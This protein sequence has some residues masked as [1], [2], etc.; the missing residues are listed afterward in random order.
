MNSFFVRWL[1]LLLLVISSMFLTTTAVADPLPGRDLLKFSQLPMISTAIQDPIIPPNPNLV[2]VTAAATPVTFTNY[3]GHDELS[4]IYGFHGS[5]PTD[6]PQTYSGR[7]MADDFADK[8]NSPVVHVK[9]W[10]SYLGDHIVEPLNRFLISFES[11]QQVDANNPFSHP[12]QPLLTQT[13][14]RATTLTPGIGAFTEKLIRSPDPVRHESLYEYNAELHIDKP[15]P[16]KAHNVYW[17]KIAA[18]IDT[19][20][21]SSNFDP[22]NPQSGPFSGDNPTVWGWHNRDYTIQDTLA[23]TAVAPGEVLDGTINGSPIYHFQDDAVGGRLIA[24][25]TGPGAPTVAQSNMTPAF[26]VDGADGPAAIAGA[27]GIS[28]YSKDLA[29]QLF[30]TQVPEPAT[31][32]L[33]AV[34]CVGSGLLRRRQANR[35]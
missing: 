6:I 7:F 8:L 13:V 31:C 19:Y 5:Q 32:I 26:Y 35:G 22:Y 2:G 17:L 1:A 27:V 16:E 29:F 9:W 3:F 10:G 30:T 25:L 24:N 14:D 4:T 11:D 12:A 21:G 33:F 15:F 34:G 20:P 18:M 28:H 23:S